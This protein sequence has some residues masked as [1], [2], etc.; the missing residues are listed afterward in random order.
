MIACLRRHPVAI[1]A[2]FDQCLALTYAVPA[3]RLRALLPPGL[4]LEALE[5][6]GFV[7]V[8]FVQARALRPAGLPAALGQDFL[9]VGY[10]IFTRFRTPAG[11][12]LRG[13]RI[14]RSDT[15]RPLM[16]IAGNML[17]H[18]NYHR[19]RARVEAAQGRVDF[20]VTTTDAEADVAVSARLDLERLPPGSPFRSER[21]ARRFA[22]PLPFTFDYERETHSIVAIE[23]SR[24]G[25]RPRLVDVAVRRMTFF[26]QP[27]FRDCTPRLAAAFRVAG[28][29]YRWE[30]G[31]RHAL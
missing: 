19:C 17:T 15:D 21:E 3:E 23:A 16:Q 7:A 9:L 2:H 24:A 12:T 26:D 25:W 11:R 14:L 6:C 28:V 1:V 4:E 30:R 29:D 10:R 5:G 22:G 8:A 13:L 31:V 20:D 27:A 18:Y